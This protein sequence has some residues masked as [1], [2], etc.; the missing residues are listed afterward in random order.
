M[1]WPLHMCHRSNFHSNDYIERKW[2]K[3]ELQRVKNELTTFC[4]INQAREL[5]EGNH[6]KEFFENFSLQQNVVMILCIPYYF[7]LYETHM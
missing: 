7:C 4:I 2:A 6:Q 5:D 3:I 1:H